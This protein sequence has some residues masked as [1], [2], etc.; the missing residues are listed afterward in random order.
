MNLNDFLVQTIEN[1]VATIPALAVLLSPIIYGLKKIK[2]VT[3]TFPKSVDD[4]K[5]KLTENFEATKNNIQGMLEQTTENLQ[6]KV[7]S[8]LLGMQEQ[9]QGYKSALQSQSEQSNFLV[10]QNKLYMDT[11]SDLV[12]Q[13]PTQI[14]NGLA[15]KLST[16]VNLTKEQLLA[17]PDLLFKDSNLLEKALVEA[18]AVLGEEKYQALLSKVHGTK[19]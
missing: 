6:E 16:K 2:D 5:Q 15:T 17:Y 18:K 1:V 13:D 10:K 14:Q 3:N 7:N 19:V 9:L 12:G 11:I 4:T 8:S